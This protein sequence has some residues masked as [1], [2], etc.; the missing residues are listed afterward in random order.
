MERSYESAA[1]LAHRAVGPLTDHL[2]EF[3]ASLT[4]QQVRPGC[5]LYQGTARA[6]VRPLAR[7]GAE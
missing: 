4:S 6:G 1:A 5:R 2:D 3:V 7:R